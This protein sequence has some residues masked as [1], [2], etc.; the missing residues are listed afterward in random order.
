LL[1]LIAATAGFGQT[2][3]QHAARLRLAQDLE[4]MG[5][6]DRA[7][8]V[9]G[10]LFNSDPRNGAYYLS[11]K[12]VLLQLRRYDDAIFVINRRLQQADDI[13]ARVDLGDVYFKRGDTEGA[14]ALWKELLQRYPH[15][16]TFGAVAAV[17]VDNRAYDEALQTY[18]QARQQLHNPM[19]FTLELASL[20]SLRLDYA[21]ATAE[22]LRYL[23]ANPRQFPF[24]QSKI[25]EMA[26]D[27]QNH[28]EAV[29]AALEGALS[30]FSQPQT[31]HRLLAGV[32]MQN[33][34]FA[35][36]LQAY[37][38]LERLASA[39][40][41]TNVGSEIFNFA[42]QA[43]NAGAHT[44]AE[45][46]YLMIV[47]DLPSSP[48]WFPAQFGLGQALQAQGKS[49]EALAAYDTMIERSSGG[50]RSPWAMRA[51]L[52]QGEIFFEHLHNME[53]AI[54]VYTQIYE[55]FAQAGGS[56]RIE[57]IFRLGDCY[58][59]RGDIRQANEWYERAKQFGRNNELIAD[60]IGYRQ[61]RLAFFQGQFRQAQKLLEAIAG[62]PAN[63][64]ETESMVNDALEML[65]LIDG[66]LADS[67]GAFLSFARAEYAAAQHNQP[68]A[69]D[70][71]ESLLQNYPHAAISPQA[72]YSLANLYS[73]Q[74]RF[75][76]AIER[77]RKILS[78]HPES[79][80]ADRSLFRLAEIHE[81]GLRNLHKA[82]ELYEQLLREYPQ[83]LY[84]EEARRRARA[85]AEKNKSS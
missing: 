79:V 16:G 2:P 77:L 35:R 62:S 38:S 45:Q 21:A 49:T 1:C 26:R 80:V 30:K 75:E 67:A 17:M 23:D 22:Y 78:Q 9:Y 51:L 74:Q 61:A 32:Y 50:G 5:Q 13:N 72:L 60:K 82:Q 66:N 69:I 15:P 24:V 44:F 58:V 4:R 53:K 42:E 54:A 71:L 18:L 41:K 6:Y 31:I 76:A 47:K 46:A 48:Y 85:L 55:R 3:Q 28:L 36:A 25:N 33:R 8:E 27:D 34:Q 29:A 65:L 19:L 20:Y 37:Q 12:R 83:S 81:T 63:E 73:D 57:A 59:A 68:A 56:E 70:T 52:A 14:R 40:D 64:R 43:R 10:A 39:E 11:L 84:L 7:A